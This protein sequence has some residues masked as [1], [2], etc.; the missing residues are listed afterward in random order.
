VTSQDSLGD[1]Y[2][3]PD[4]WRRRLVVAAS[5]L[6]ALVFLGWLAWAVWGNATPDVDSEMVTYE[7]VDEHHAT[8][9]VEVRLSGADVRA[10]CVLQ[11]VAE[12]H[13]VVGELAFTPEYGARQP[14]ELTVRTERRATSVNLVGCTAPGQP[15][16][17]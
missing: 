12:D 9:R 16:P 7:V 8:A 15:R 11:A 17:R 6:L 13:T 10:S 5:A 2:G 4:P 1:R 14:L 3:A